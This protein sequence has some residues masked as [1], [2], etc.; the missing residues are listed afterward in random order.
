MFT[1][2]YQPN[3][4]QVSIYKTRKYFLFLIIL[5]FDKVPPLEKECKLP[6][7]ITINCEKKK[8]NNE[9]NVE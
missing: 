3:S 9:K 8:K 5:G 7:M 2:R 4:Y 1:S 6:F